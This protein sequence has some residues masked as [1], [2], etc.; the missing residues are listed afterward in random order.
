LKTCNIKQLLFWSGEKMEEII[1][2]DEED[3]Q[4]N[5][6]ENIRKRLKE[7]VKAREQ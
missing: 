7:F 3:N 4:N 6:N 1:G 5:Q 2:D